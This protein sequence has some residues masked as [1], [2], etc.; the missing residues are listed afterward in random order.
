MFWIDSTTRA[1]DSFAWNGSACKH[2]QLATQRCRAI[3]TCRATG[4]IPDGCAL[5]HQGHLWVAIFGGG[6]VRRFDTTTGRLLGVVTLPA[7]A[8]LMVTACAF[9][10]PDL[11]ELYITTADGSHVG[12]ETGVLAGGLF[13]VSRDQLAKL[14]GAI[15]GAAT[16][17]FAR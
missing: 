17:D 1:V 5:D 4:E 3:E 11:A 16:H 13:T 15:R 6:C 10:G 12:K 2:E 8:G 7:E 9:G 14:G